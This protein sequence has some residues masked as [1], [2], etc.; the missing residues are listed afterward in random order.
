MFQALIILS[1]AWI[2]AYLQ[3]ETQVS[4]RV[5]MEKV[6]SQSDVEGYSTLR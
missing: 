6:R 1:T 5:E 2:P 3:E 4:L